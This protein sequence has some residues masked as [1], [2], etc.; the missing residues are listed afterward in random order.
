MTTKL[1]QWP[2]TSDGMRIIVPT[3]IQDYLSLNPLSRQCYPTAF[4]YYPKA[5]GHRM[6][7]EQH[8]DNLLMYCTAGQGTL[9]IGPQSLPV[10]P[11]DA[12]M[13]PKGSHHR[14]QADM[15]NPWTIYWVHFE[16]E[17]AEQFLDT[18]RAGRAFAPV[19]FIGTHSR[20]VADFEA[21]IETRKTG[22]S[23]RSFVHA[24]NLLRQMLTYLSV[25]APVIQAKRLH[26]MDLDGIHALMEEN[27]HGQL[28]LATLAAYAKLSKYHFSNKYKALTGH[29]PIQH[30]LHLKMERACH[31]LDVSGISI[32]DVGRTLGYEDSY[33][34]SRLFKKIIGVAPRQYRNLKRG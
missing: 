28:D 32:K 4:G 25:V 14:Y 9:E 10:G 1:S 31:L 6:S 5:G 29:S 33:Y 24:A 26:D 2:L 13:L 27:L 17:L 11:G 30:F 22:Y 21:L 8:D 15:D 7:R 20:L 18:V 3:F 19:L 34:F 16:G 12:L 23:R